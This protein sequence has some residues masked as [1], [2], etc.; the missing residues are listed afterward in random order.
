MI[1]V[2]VKALLRPLRNF[3]DSRFWAL[4][5]KEINQILRNRQLIIL[6]IVPPTVQLLLYGFALNPDVHGLKLGVVDYAQVSA[7]RELVSALTE[8]KIF[9]IDTYPTNEKQLAKQVE[10]GELT[11]GMV[12]PPD[13]NRKLQ[14]EKSA[15]I[16]IFIDGVDANTAGIASGYISQIVNRYNRRLSGIQHTHLVSAQVVFL[17]NPGLNSSWFFVPGVMGLVLTLIGTLV[18]AITVVSEKDTGTLEQLLMTPAAAWEILLAKI[19]P[20]FFLLFADVMLALTLGTIVFGLPFRGSFLLFVGLSSMYLFVGI[21][22][23]IMLA[24]VSQ[25]QQQ[26]VLTAFFINLPLVQT[27]GAIAPI[28]TMPPFFQ[29]LSLLNP[30]RHYITIVR[31]ILLK[32]VGLEALWMHVLA[33]ALFAVVLMSISINKFRDQLT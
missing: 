2:L 18:S 11:A 31:G 29:I 21:S 6:L 16:Q 17:Y 26:V 30:L 15:D 12:I 23:G 8:N 1:K 19:V 4:A 14:S 24:T 32:G 28:E 5:Q 10:A 7:S 9:V 22:L 27:S 13:F 25:S 20:L 3:F 33:L